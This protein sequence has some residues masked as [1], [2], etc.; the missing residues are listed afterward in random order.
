MRDF[1]DR[2]TDEDIASL[3]SPLMLRK[4]SGTFSKAVNILR[5]G[6]FLNVAEPSDG[7]IRNPAFP[8]P[9]PGVAT[10]GKTI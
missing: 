2:G 5:Y 9:G 6:D 7:C 4:Q 3:T 1:F 8:Y 10:A